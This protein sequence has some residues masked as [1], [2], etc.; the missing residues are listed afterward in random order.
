MEKLNL[1]I[2]ETEIGRTK[3][4]VD[5]VTKE[6]SVLYGN[7]VYPKVEG[8]TLTVSEKSYKEKLDAFF[9]SD[10]GKKYK[11]PSE[12]QILK[13]MERM[14]EVI[15]I[16]EKHGGEKAAKKIE[17]KINRDKR[18]FSKPANDQINDLLSGVL[19]NYENQPVAKMDIEKVEEEE[20][21]DE[22]EK[23]K[24]IEESR[25]LAGI[26][27][28][29][30]DVEAE[31]V[32]EEEPEEPKDPIDVIND[33]LADLDQKLLTNE[34]DHKD[35]R[36]DLKLVND[37]FNKNITKFNESVNITNKDV[38]TILK[39]V[40]GCILKIRDQE[41]MIHSLKTTNTVQMVLI[42]ILIIVVIFCLLNIVGVINLF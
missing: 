18:E 2:G 12:A 35:F 6:F 22:A 36:K 19:W 16:V 20:S 37:G 25:E 33:K 11:R 28:R 17:E 41:D 14:R 34:N 38:D 9:E 24:I 40:N 13:D 3:A 26:L 42:V 5:G 31:E 10:E 8:K 4:K 30:G 1:K 32:K 29:F 39:R 23:E 7:V 15:N 21:A 27:S